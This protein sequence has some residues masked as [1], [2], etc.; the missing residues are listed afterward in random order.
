VSR[1][2]RAERSV[3]AREPLRLTRPAEELRRDF[4]RFSELRDELSA[5]EPRVLALHDAAQLLRSPPAPPHSDDICRR[6]LSH[7]WHIYSYL[8]ADT[9]PLDLC[10]YCTLTKPITNEFWVDTIQLNEFV[11]VVS[12]CNGWFFMSVL[13]PSFRVPGDAALVGSHKV[14]RRS[15]EGRGK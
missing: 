11:Q 13:F 6:Y 1:L 12:I 15:G 3:R 7:P 14:D 4:A 5:A 2:G 9:Y 8:Y 10:N